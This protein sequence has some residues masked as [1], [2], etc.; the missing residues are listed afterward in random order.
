MF[1]AALAIDSMALS[2]HRVIFSP[3]DTDAYMSSHHMIE[4]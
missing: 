3:F 4:Y 2:H 1:P